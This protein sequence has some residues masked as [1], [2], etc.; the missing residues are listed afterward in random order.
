MQTAPATVAN[1]GIS[2]RELIQ[3]LVVSLLANLALHSLN[4]TTWSA[5]AK[6]LA[7]VNLIFLFACYVVLRHVAHSNP[8]A[9]A[10]LRD[11][12]VAVIASCAIVL[13]SFIGYRF[14]VG[15]LTTVAALYILATAQDDKALRGAGT[16]LMAVSFNVLWA[17]IIFRYFLPHILW[18]DAA[19]VKIVLWAAS[20][21]INVVDTTFYSPGDHVISLV[22]ACS[23]FNNVSLAMLAYVSITMLVR[24]YWN[25]SDLIWM[26]GLCILMI[27]FN[28]VRLSILARDFE[29]YLYWHDLAGKQYLALAQTFAVVAVAYVGARKGVLNQ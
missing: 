27:A 29:S 24:T 8:V 23:S 21:D 3:W 1:I 28:A 5:F 13:S 9:G 11:I 25:R 7:S 18:A 14:G 4:T 12:T 20:S 26:A 17:G 10:N 22:G 15:A 19:V 16:V 6:S 2:R